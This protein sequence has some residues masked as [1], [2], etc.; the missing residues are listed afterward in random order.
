MKG[1]FTR[2]GR[3]VGAVLLVFLFSTAGWAENDDLA[4]LRRTGK[5]FTEVAKEAVPAVVAVQSEYVVSSG[6][7]FPGSPFDEDFFERFFGP[8]FRS[9]TPQEQ[10]QIGQGSGFIIS[11]DG[12]V[13]TNH[14]VVAEADKITILTNDGSKYEN[15]QLIGSDEKAD[16]ALL[17]IKDV[18]DL[19]AVKLG[20]SDK[21]QIGEWVIAVGNPFGLTE[22]VTVGVV[23][24]KG[25]KLHDDGA[26]VYEDFI[27]TDAAINPGNSGGPLLNIDG[28][29]IGINAAIITGDRGYMGIGMAVPINMARSI[30]DQLIE[31]GKVTRG[32][33]G[34]DLQDL[35]E[36]IAKALDLKVRR[37]D[38]ITSV[39]KDSPAEQAG[40]KEQDII[41]EINGRRVESSQDAKNL[42][43]FAA[44]GTELKILLIN[45]EGQ[46]KEIKLTTGTKPVDEELI[47]KLGIQIKNAE[48]KENVVITEV[49]SG[50]EAAR[51]LRPGMMILSINRVPVKTV[52]EFM[53]VLKKAEDQGKGQVALLVQ[54][55]M[56]AFWVALPLE[57]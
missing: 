39:E 17:K 51:V 49:Q 38:I 42:I 44:P 3:G 36:D 1:S 23:S 40:L 19:P 16:V 7:G 25:R 22:T 18:K 52:K 5:A 21:L 6:S 15:V 37:G 55:E 46:E 30:K 47:N 12:Y 9:R 29:V 32:Y 53:E 8:R 13:L 14:H 54:S 11:E 56:Y 28:E 10:R 33:A 26:D 57:K 4:M 43:G 24:A 34:I 41:T 27:Q 35:N 31:T 2:K 48:D 50:T 20:D 45:K